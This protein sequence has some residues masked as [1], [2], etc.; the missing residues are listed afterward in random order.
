MTAPR[1]VTHNPGLSSGAAPGW[2][3]RSGGPVVRSA[4]VFPLACARTI[5]DEL[6][7]ALDPATLAR[8]TPRAAPDLALLQ[9]M[10]ALRFTG[11]SPFR[12]VTC[13][14]G[15]HD[16]RQGVTE[17]WWML[18]APGGQA[19]GIWDTLVRAMRRH[20]AGAGRIAVSLSGGLDSSAIAAAAARAAL[21]EA[22]PAPLLVAAR[23]PGMACDESPWQEAVARH[24]GLD[25]ATVDAA[26]LPLWPAAREAMAQGT[27][28][29]VDAM[30][31]VHRATGAMALRE[32]CRRMAWGV[33]GDE[34]FDERGL[35]I[36]LFRSGRWMAGAT[37]ALRGRLARRRAGAV[38]TLARGIR[39]AIRPARLGLDA[40]G[41]RA[42]GSWRH[43]LLR[44]TLADP[45]LAWRA[46]MVAD[47]MHRAG[48][49][50]ALPLL[51]R[52]VVE[53]VAA[54]RSSGIGAR[55][56]PR[57][58]LREAV[59]PHL[60]GAVVRRV[61]KA[62]LTEWFHARVASEGSELVAAWDGL[63]RTLDVPW[64][65]M[66]ITPARLATDFLTGWVGLGILHFVAVHHSPG[67]V[68]DERL[69]APS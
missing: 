42:A 49:E 63:R 9:D 5:G 17:P 59:A 38:R 10:A 61:E 7:L 52:V 30:E 45:R 31:A 50:L 36:D 68:A 8:L 21:E 66:R 24:L 4:P 26:A 69:S 43:A 34:L 20:V 15:G 65:P 51:D 53:A 29:L 44:R 1:V 62:D 2:V 35:E 55:W 16:S 54:R 12:E 32:G 3:E 64:L 48:L 60:P 33:G 19:P 27:S 25:L 56:L 6:H 58:L 37:V 23:F 11:L 67:E 13:V 18:P 47:T 28:P 39:N 57:M 14:P 41:V 40:A 22:R 46:R